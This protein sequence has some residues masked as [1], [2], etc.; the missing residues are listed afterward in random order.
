MHSFRKY[1]HTGFMKKKQRTAS[2]LLYNFIGLTVAIGGWLWETLVFLVK[3]QRFVNRGFLYGPYL[4]VYGMGAV[5]LC[6][7]FYHKK[8]TVMITYARLKSADYPREFYSGSLY[9]R[10]RH[11]IRQAG[12]RRRIPRF[13]SVSLQLQKERVP[14]KKGRRILADI[15]VFLISMCGGCLTELA[16]G[17]LLMHGFHRRYWDYRGYPLNLGGYI[18]LFSA[19]G[20]GIAGVLWMKWAGP[21]LIRT[22]ERLRFSVQILMIGLCDLI[23]VTDVIFSLMH[24]NEGE[25]I[26]F[27]MVVIFFRE[28]QAK[29][30]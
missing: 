2:V 30:R 5:L 22:W 8:I 11:L 20:F 24:P 1:R 13:T 16:T 25:Y 18:C 6:I 7:L 29:I 19:L 21:F 27:S 4:P 23:F 26:T 14:A 12:L 15:R 17:W 9:A 3:D 28:C 10:L